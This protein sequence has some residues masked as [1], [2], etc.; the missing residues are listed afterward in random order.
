[1]VELNRAVAVSMADGP[2]AA[3][4]I[5]DALSDVVVL[6]G[7]HLLPAVRGDLP[8]KL[9]RR[10]EARWEFERAAAM[11]G[12]EPSGGCCSTGPRPAESAATTEGKPRASM[13]Y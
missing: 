1:M 3:L 6:R 10:D 13:T 5:V 12:N 7:Y 4:S 8:L 2:T 11:T 9:E